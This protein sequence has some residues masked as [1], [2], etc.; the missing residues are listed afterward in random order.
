MKRNQIQIAE[1]FALP[2]EIV[3]QTI[4]LLAKRRAGKSYLARKIAEQ[5]FGAD[6]QIVIVDPKGDWWGIRSAANGRDPGLPIVIFGGERGDVNLEASGG[7]LVAKLVVEERVSALL[8][9]SLFR[10]HEVA[11]FMTGF[12]EALYRLKALERNRTPMMLLVDEADAIAP[13]NPQKGEER[14]LGAAEDIVRRGGQRGIGCTLITQRSAVLSKNVLTQAEVLIALRTISPQDLKA[15]GAW[16][17]VHGTDEQ[18]KVLMDSLPS[19]PI[20]D[21]W[22][23]SPGWPTSGGIFERIHTAPIATFDSGASPK[24]G[25]KP[26]APKKLADVDLAAVRAQMAA[27][28]EKAKQDDPRELR[29][30]IAELEKQIKAVKAERSPPPALQPKAIEVPVFSDA[31]LKALADLGKK[32]GELQATVLGAMDRAGRQ[33]ERATKRLTPAP[34]RTTEPVAA[35]IP[36]RVEMAAR[37]KTML[38][39]LPPIDERTAHVAKVAPGTLPAGARKLLAALATF[40]P[41]ALTRAQVATL[42]GLSVKGGTFGTYLSLLKTNGLIDVAGDGIRLIG[43]GVHYPGGDTPRTR[44]QI[45]ALWNKHL[46]AGARAMLRCVVDEG[47]ISRDLLGHRTNIEPSGGTFGTYL[48][49]LTTNGLVE[50]NGRAL[51]PGPAMELVE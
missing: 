43:E 16:I 35:R 36:T 12:L 7:E 49:L 31:S 38:E 19:L 11:T 48:S 41:K 15:I 45:I 23:W 39:H 10:K 46:P 14:M 24:P 20:G 6:Q 28:I 37:R 27:T 9:L 32:V 42:A 18:R 21:S 30:R 2:V 47:P 4:A 51:V 1:R 34:T 40:A 22:V 17:D 44:E 25:H 13:Q 8:D 33:I 29:R 5:L 26:V 50:K 3:T